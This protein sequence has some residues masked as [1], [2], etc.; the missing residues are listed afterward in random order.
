MNKD[1]LNVLRSISKNSDST[2]RQMAKDLGFS[3]GKINYCL[4]K[5]QEKGLIKM[6]IFKK[7]PNKIN[8]IYIL[9]PKGLKEKVKLTLNF[10]KRMMKEYDELEN[11][12]KKTNK[13]DN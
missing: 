7:N 8:Y 11:E 6:K 12:I 3:I 9:T 4:K 13:N 5:L 2:Q 10:M 1:F